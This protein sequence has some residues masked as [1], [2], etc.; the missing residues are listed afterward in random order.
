MG[1]FAVGHREYLDRDPGCDEGLEHSAC[2]EH[3][4]IGMR[5]DNDHSAGA[6]KFDC[7]KSPQ[8]VRTDPGL[9]RCAEMGLVYE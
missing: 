7:R 9:L 1:A 8:V 2:P 4:I 6:S 5:C 3:L